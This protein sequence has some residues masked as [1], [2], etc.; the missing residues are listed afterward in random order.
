M[1]KLFITL[2]TLSFFG[3]GCSAP[4]L[5]RS[6]ADQMAES[7]AE[8]A[9]GGKV[10]IASD[11]GTVEY[12][13]QKGNAVAMGENATLPNG[14]PT[15][16]PR[17]PG[18]T[19][20]AASTTDDQHAGLSVRTTDDSAKVMTWLEDELKK[21]GWTLKT[22]MGGTEFQ[23][24]TFEKGTNKLTVTTLPDGEGKGGTLVTIGRE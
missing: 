12:S 6:A 4:S 9:T 18:S 10:N 8:R 7:A 14:F 2:A 21:N 3:F 24:R 5:T 22:T 11:K 19:L 23:A 13:D 20:V 17:Y 1:K 15:D 16:I